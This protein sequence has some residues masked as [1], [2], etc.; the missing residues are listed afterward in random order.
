[1][2]RLKLDYVLF[3]DEKIYTSHV[4]SKTRLYPD[5][6]NNIT[7]LE[8]SYRRLKSFALRPS[9]SKVTVTDTVSDDCK[10]ILQKPNNAP[11]TYKKLVN[12][13]K[14]FLVPVKTYDV[15]QKDCLIFTG[16]D[17]DA[18]QCRLCGS[19]RYRKGK[20]AFRKYS[21]MPIG[22]RRINQVP[23]TIR[24]WISGYDIAA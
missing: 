15:C 14:A 5:G 22:P 18:E 11:D 16:P 20:E 17:S 21:Y 7:I 4:A 8:Y 3:F 12:N 6:E 10:Y 19:A 2:K 9:T 1:M 24:S 13:I 23:L